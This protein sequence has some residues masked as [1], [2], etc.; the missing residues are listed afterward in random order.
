[1]FLY[2]I[3]MNQVKIKQKSVKRE[4]FFFVCVSLL[5]QM[6]QLKQI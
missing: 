1:M 2:K 5:F 6:L 4:F 3:A